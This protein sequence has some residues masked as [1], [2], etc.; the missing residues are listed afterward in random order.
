MSKITF[1]TLLFWLGVCD[2]QRSICDAFYVHNKTLSVIGTGSNGVCQSIIHHSTSTSPR[3]LSNTETRVFEAIARGID[4]RLLRTQSSGTEVSEAIKIFSKQDHTHGIYIR[5]PNCWAHDLDLTC[6]SPWNSKGH[7]RRAGTLISPRNAVWARH[8]NIPVNT[9]LRFVDMNNKVVERRIIQSIALPVPAHANYMSG[10]DMVI[11]L[12]D[13]DVPSSVTFAKVL[14][15][16]FTKIYGN[17]LHHALPVLST[18]YSEKALVDDLNAMNNKI[19]SLS[20]PIL[21]Y[22]HAYYESKIVGDSGNPSF[23]VIDN[24]LVLLFVFTYGGAGSGTS[25]QYHYDD[26]NDAMHSLGSRYSLTE[27]DLSQYAT[28]SQ[29]T[30]VFG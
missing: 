5:N 10:Y 22:R 16:N 9:T 4:S 11:G 29:I 3:P 1:S 15:R 17:H 25:V 27:I 2:Y 18:D 26:I 24:Q 13:H 30:N 20:V 7:T 12:L 8:Y 19:V 14:P 6:I 21:S 28:E 23:F